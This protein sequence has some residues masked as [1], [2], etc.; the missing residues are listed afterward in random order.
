MVLAQAEVV[1]G[2]LVVEVGAAEAGSYDIA[3]IE[4]GQRVAVEHG[5]RGHRV[6]PA[7]GYLRADVIRDDGA[8]AWVEPARR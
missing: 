8:E 7:T 6:L 4:N 5:K 2:E 3:S 1:A